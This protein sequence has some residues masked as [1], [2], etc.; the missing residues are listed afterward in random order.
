MTYKQEYDRWIRILRL[1]WDG[2]TFRQIGDAV[3]LSHEHCRFIFNNKP[4]KKKKYVK[5]TKKKRIA[6]SKPPKKII[7]GKHPYTSFVGYFIDEPSWRMQGR[8]RV[9]FLVRLRDNMTCRSCSKVW[10]KGERHFDVHHLN[11]VCGQKSTK[12]DRLD[13]M[14][15]LITLCHKCH[16]NHPEHT[17]QT[18]G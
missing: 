15:G 10:E 11:G 14:D 8:E 3:N 12:Y 5:K 13:E 6:K 16:F 2:N 9:R 17:L 4:I 7:N 1:R 18:R